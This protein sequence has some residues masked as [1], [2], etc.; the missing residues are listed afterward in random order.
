MLN[1]K[2]RKMKDNRLLNNEEY[3]TKDLM[4]TI[5]KH[6]KEN[7][8]ILQRSYEYEYKEKL[9]VERLLHSFNYIENNKV[10]AIEP[11]FRNEYGKISK[12][13]VPYGVVGVVIKNDLTLYQQA[14]IINLLI[15]TKNSII[16]EPYRKIGTLNILIEMINQ[17]ITQVN[18][19]NEIVINGSEEKLQ[20][21]NNLDLMLFIGEKEEF[22]RLTNI[23]EK[24]YC[25]IGNYELIIDKEIDK[26]LIEEAKKQGI[27]IIYKDDNPNFFSE[28]NYIGSNYCTGFMS[29]S[30]EEVRKFINN[31]KSSYILINA[32]PTL[33]D[34]INITID[35]VVYKKS[36]LLWEEFK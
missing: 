29:D 9:D 26:N 7:I 27:K 11:I 33:Q 24:K 5:K 36:T 28:F 3:N 32:I 2:I 10:G 18:G 15:Q 17:I 23:C 12:S 13:Y 4:E 22:R 30:K 19:Y 16:I 20:N 6:L 35:D 31:I 8:D 1:E 14:E 25:G 21:N 34:D